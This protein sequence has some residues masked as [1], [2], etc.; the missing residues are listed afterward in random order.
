MHGLV[1]IGTAAGSAELEAAAALCEAAR[2]DRSRPAAFVASASGPGARRAISLLGSDP[3]L[4]ERAYE[5]VA[6]PLLAARLEGKP[7]LTRDGL[8]EAAARA[9][10]GGDL[11]VVATSGGLLAPLAARYSNRDLAGELGLAVVV[12]GA[13]GGTPPHAA[14]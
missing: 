4:S 12:A 10:E 11:L 13:G 7:E 3:E 8:L 5:S 9:G 6:P 1:I 2:E 14:P